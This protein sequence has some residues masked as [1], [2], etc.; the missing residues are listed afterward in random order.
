MAQRIVAG[1]LVAL[2]GMQPATA[3]DY[4]SGRDVFA[5]Y[6]AGC[7]GQNGRSEMPGMPDFANG[8]ALLRADVEIYRSIRS[9]RGAMPAF[10][11]LLSETQIRDVIVY[12]RSLQ[13]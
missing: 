9:G 8:D 10:E 11:G 3:A 4:F 12:L 7:H 2:C 13:R 1:W 5:T 6:C